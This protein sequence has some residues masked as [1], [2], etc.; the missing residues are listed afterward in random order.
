VLRVAQPGAIR[1]GN[2]S[3]SEAHLTSLFDEILSQFGGIAAVETAGAKGAQSPAHDPHAMFESVV[4]LITQYGGLSGLL[5]KLKRAGLGDAVSSWVGTGENQPVSGNQLA[6][7]VGPDTIAQIA[8]KLGITDENV[9]S[10]LSK[11]L[12]MVIDHLTP[13]GKVE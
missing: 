4:G 7:A 6:S 13:K 1:F 3:P 8:A 12:P 11:Y 2:H 10:L 9:R 5:E